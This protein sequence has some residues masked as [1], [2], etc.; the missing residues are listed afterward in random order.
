MYLLNSHCL[1]LYIWEQQYCYNM[2]DT[3]PTIIKC[4]IGQFP[5]PMPEGMLDPMP[6]VKVVFDN[7]VEKVLFDFFPDE[8][9][10]TED[11]FIGLTEEAA[12][13]LRTEKDIKF[14]QS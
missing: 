12:I 2:K 9:S 13:R 10:F 3:Q 8:I 5:R 4:E 7:G 6:E 11:E 14:L 1:I